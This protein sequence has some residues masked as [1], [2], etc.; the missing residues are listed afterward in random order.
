MNINFSLWFETND[1]SVK[2]YS[3]IEHQKSKEEYE[4]ANP[5]T[6]FIRRNV[7]RHAVDH[8]T[9][10]GHYIPKW[11]VER[12]LEIEKQDYPPFMQMLRKHIE[13]ENINLDKISL[14]DIKD[15]NALDEDDRCKG[16][17]VF[18][19]GEDWF[20]LGCNGADKMEIYDMAA[21]NSKMTLRGIGQLEKFLE[22]FKTKANGQPKVFEVTAR[23]TTSWQLVWR[24]ERNGDIK[25]L[26]DS[27]DTWHWY[28]DEDE[29]DMQDVRN[30]SA[31]LMHDVQFI[32]LPKQT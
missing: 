25:I 3:D 4:K 17:L 27:H 28:A 24:M 1:T 16:D 20:I 15:T 7:S 14:E 30:H 31:E 32:F 8:L 6:G 5:I 9:N 10:K 29:D 18:F 21:R 2:T 12:L 11:V 22:R 23:D 26:P 13:E 19:I